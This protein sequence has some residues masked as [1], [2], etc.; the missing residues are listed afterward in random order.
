ALL[1]GVYPTSGDDRWIAITIADAAMWR[2]FT[3]L[4][5]ESGWPADPSRLSPAEADALD[6]RIASWTARHVG[7]ALML[8]LQRAGVAAGEAQDARDIVEID[9][10]LRLRG[11]LQD[12]EH[13]LLGRFACQATP[14]SLSRS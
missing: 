2:R 5:G 14:I 3:S 8:E 13:P 12:V 10:Q 4:T 7:R 9:P 11:F 1:Q 6:E